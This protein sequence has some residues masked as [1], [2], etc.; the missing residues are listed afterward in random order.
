MRGWAW[1]EGEDFAVD[2]AKVG[3]G[4]GLRLLMPAVEMTRLDVG[5]GD[6]GHWRVHFATFSKME[7]Q[8]Q[9]LR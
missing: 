8:R 5:I 4:I 2:R 6:D 7:A 1:N 9:C 3:V